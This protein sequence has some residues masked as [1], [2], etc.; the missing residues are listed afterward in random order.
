MATTGFSIAGIVRRWGTET[1]AAP[2]FVCGT[3]HQTWGQTYD[4]AKQVAGALVA[5]GVGS[6]DRVAFLDKNG[7]EYFDVL[8]GGALLNAVN[9]AVNWR[10]AP[11]EMSFIINDAEATVLFVHADFL[12]HLAQMR[13]DLMTVK[14]VVVIGAETTSVGTG[15]AEWLASATPSDPGEVA[16]DGDVAMQLY[17]SGTTGLPKGVMLSNWNLSGLVEGAGEL[18]ITDPTIVN[19]L[20][21]MPLFHIGGSGWALLGLTI[22]ARSTIVREIDPA[23]V[24]ALLA[25]GVTHAFLVPAVL[26]FCLIAPADGL[27]FSSLK[28]IAYGASPISEDV[29]TRCM[30]RYGCDFFQLYGLTETTGGICMLRPEDHT[31]ETHR[32]RLRSAGRPMPGVELRIVDT[33]TGATIVADDVVGEVWIKAPRNCSG[34][35]G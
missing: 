32:E 9:V 15:W 21:A 31:D 7:I 3:L 18:D 17:T 6:Q 24:Q 29:L 2:A 4:M 11:A 26:S 19:S 28:A 34:V 33:L 10:L 35:G 5:A 14:H 1:P 12:D 20:V 8:L 25:S 16:A 23:V 27:D 22:G 30:D 13:A